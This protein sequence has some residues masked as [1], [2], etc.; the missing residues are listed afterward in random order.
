MSSRNSPSRSNLVGPLAAVLL[1]AGA[2]AATIAYKTRLAEA[3][4]PPRGRF[5]TVSGVRLHYI[6]AGAGPP[7]V[8]LHGNG[9]MTEDMRISGAF[10]DFSETHRTVAYDR[11][12]FGY[13]GRPRS[14]SWTPEAQARLIV[15]ANTLLGIDRP[16]IFAHSWG[17]LVALALALDHPERVGGLVLVS[18]FYYPGPGI[19]TVG[20]NPAA[21]PVLGDV[22]NHTVSPWIGAA[23]SNM[24]IKGMFA[25]E[26]VPP[27]FSREFP[28]A[29]T[30]RPSQIK[31][32]AEESAGMNAAAASLCERYYELRCPTIIVAG[33]ADKI[34]D[35]G[36]AQRLHATIPSST[37]RIWPGASHM[38]HHRFSGELARAIEHMGEA[39]GTFIERLCF[40]L[41]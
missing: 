7:V 33:E 28:I 29:L 22:L 14:T 16:I 12:G 26:G 21:T 3:S 38:L 17:T 20:F 31:A 15:E 9:A 40:V 8:M 37:L 18:G 11:P 41:M 27:R 36:Q 30:L 6:E 32:F 39:P 19:G 4:H 25:P 24:M 35:T 10:A 5:V 1:A 23:M 2:S 34:V 13:S